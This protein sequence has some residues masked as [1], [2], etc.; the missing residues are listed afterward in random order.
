MG[1]GRET[2]GLLGEYLQRRAGG[3][4]KGSEASASDGEV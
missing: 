1:M 2:S 4:E 3:K